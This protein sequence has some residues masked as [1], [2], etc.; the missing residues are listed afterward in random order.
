MKN[1]ILDNYN[2]YIIFENGDIYDT[3]TNKNVHKIVS[4]RNK[5][6]S[7]N[8]VNSNNKKVHIELS[9]LLAMAFIENNNN[10]EKVR[11]KDNN[12]LN[13]NLDNLEWFTDKNRYKFY[14]DY[15]VIIDTN[16]NI[17]KIDKEDYQKVSKFQWY[18]GEDGYFRTSKTKEHKSYFLHRFILN[19][20]NNKM[21]DHINRDK[22]DNRKVNLRMATPLQN[23]QN[24]SIAKT[25]T[26]GIIGVSKY[27]ETK[28]GIKWRAYIK[29][30]G[31]TIQLLKSYDF[32]K[33]VI[34]RLRAEKEYF[35]EFAPQR[36]LFEKYGI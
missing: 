33:C 17:A 20:K 35:G 23:S 18:K 4:K 36:D 2:R 30:N 6:L 26:S 5:S 8:I 15:V 16:N 12:V 7:V 28:N 24:Q 27:Y 13:N 25:N 3:K 34:A 14:N 9:K 10:F 31:K 19:I 32:Q 22:T 11:H 21:V 29:L 1:K